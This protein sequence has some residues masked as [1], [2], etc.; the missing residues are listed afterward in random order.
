MR[1]T[2]MKECQTFNPVASED[3]NS[4]CSPWVLLFLLGLQLPLQTTGSTSI[5]ISTVTNTA[6][7][8]A[9]I[10]NSTSTTTTTT[11]ITTATT[12]TT[13]YNNNNN[14]NNYYYY[15]YYYFKSKVQDKWKAIYKKKFIKK[16]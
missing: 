8:T 14:N 10:Y 15:N 11:T 12:T 16:S 13:Y 7:A 3:S 2:P 6:A 1:M 4:T 9:S 5:S